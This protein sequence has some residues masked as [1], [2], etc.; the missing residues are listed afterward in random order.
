MFNVKISIICFGEHGPKLKIRDTFTA[1]SKMKW[2]VILRISEIN[3]KWWL[4]KVKNM[5]LRQ[6]VTCCGRLPQAKRS[7]REK[8]RTAN[9]IAER[10][11]LSQSRG[12]A[13]NSLWGEIELKS[14]IIL[15]N[16]QYRVNFLASYENT[17][18]SPAIRVY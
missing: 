17:Y 4:E 5:V 6:T 7:F 18:T 1:A 2:L 13:T 8:W 16:F 3:C 12:R 14:L 10:P 15:R 9:Q 11:L